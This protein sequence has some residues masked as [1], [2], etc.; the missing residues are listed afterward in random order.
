M[1]L[2]QA[3]FEPAAVRSGEGS[4]I[5]NGSNAEQISGHRDCVGPLQLLSHRASQHIGQ[6]DT[7][8]TS[9]G[10]ILR[11]GGWMDQCRHRRALIRNGVMV[12]DDHVHAQL[13]RQFQRLPRGHAVV[14]GDQQAHTPVVEFVHHA[15]IETVTVFHPGGN[16]S[17]RMGS[18]RFEC[19]QQQC[20]A[21][22]PISV[23]ITADGK[24]PLLPTDRHQTLHCDR[25]IGEMVQRIGENRWIEPLQS[26]LD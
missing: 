3:L 9:V 15:W 19:T 6:T 11:S 12:G 4:H 14:D 2:A 8:Q 7:G 20:C 26:S 13:L 10:R 24:I 21:G 18:E 25:K 22:H 17:N 1:E 16:R 5:R 23:V